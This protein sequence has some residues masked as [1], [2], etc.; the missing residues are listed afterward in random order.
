MHPEPITASEAVTLEHPYD[1]TG[2][3]AGSPTPGELGERVDRAL[4]R[5]QAA[6]IDAAHHRGLIPTPPARP[7]HILTRWTASVRQV[8]GTTVDLAWEPGWQIPAGTVALT[9]VGTL[10]GLDSP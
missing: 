4:I 7:G 9:C 10:H 6:L 3:R 5:L 8:G 2:R 1:P